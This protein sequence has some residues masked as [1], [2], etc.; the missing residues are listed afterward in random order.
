MRSHETLF[1]FLTRSYILGDKV[2]LDDPVE[3]YVC[4]MIAFHLY[5]LH[6]G[7]FCFSWHI[8]DCLIVFH[9]S[10]YPLEKVQAY[11]SLR[12]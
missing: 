10:G 1:F 2:I 6:L 11:S 3:R 5:L 8:C 7:I 4:M 9:S 12:L